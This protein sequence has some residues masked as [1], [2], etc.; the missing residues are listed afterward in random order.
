[1]LFHFMVEL[2][3]LRRVVAQHRCTHLLASCAAI[4]HRHSTHRHCAVT[5]RGTLYAVQPPSKAL[6]YYV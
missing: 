4:N 2:E 3:R 1:V 5:R 6:R